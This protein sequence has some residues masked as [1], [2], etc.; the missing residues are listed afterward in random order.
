METFEKDNQSMFNMVNQNSVLRNQVL[1]EGLKN[2]N[3]AWERTNAKTKGAYRE[4]KNK[5]RNQINRAIVATVLAVTS[6]ISANVS[7]NITKAS[8]NRNNAVIS[9]TKESKNSIDE[10]ISY[11]EKLMN[12]TSDE[13]NRIENGYGRNP[14]T[15]E[16]NVDYN[17]SNLARHIV[18]SS[19]ISESEMRCVIIAAYNIINSPYREETFDKAFEIAKNSENMSEDTRDLI[20]KGSKGFLEELQYNNWE[21][22]QKNERQEIKDLKTIEKYSGGK[23]R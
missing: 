12:H 18:E 10:R 22:Y 11:Y 16:L 4:M 7:K 5:K 23:S 21:E 3:A 15:D 14:E 9:E 17:Y 6:F 2:Y 1:E 13:Q 19:Q 20:E 8:I